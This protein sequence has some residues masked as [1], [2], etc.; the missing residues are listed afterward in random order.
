[1]TRRARVG[2]SPSL[3]PFLAVLVCTLG[4][5]ILLLALVAQNAT[6]S[7]K[8]QAEA[9]QA[10]E[11]LAADNA[12]PK[13]TREVV[14]RMIQ[15]GEFRVT[16]LVSFRDSQTADLEERRDK[17]THLEDHIR[18]IRDELTQLNREVELA[19]STSPLTKIEEN[20]VNELKAKL[21]SERKHVEELR[22]SAQSKKPRVVIVPHKG[23]NGTDRRPVYLECT[24]S[25]ITIWPESS[26]IEINELMAIESNSN[27]LDAALRTVRMY[28]MQN[29]GDT[30]PPYPLL[31]VR[32][33][34][35]ETYG[36]ARQ[37]MLDWDDQFGYELVPAD[38]DLAFAKPDSQ[39][40]QKVDIAIRDA[41]A[42]Q[43]RQ[44]SIAGLAIGR[45]GSA[46]GSGS[47]V[48]TLSAAELDRDG[49]SGGF[50]D[51]RDRSLP[52]G[53]YG[54]PTNY[55]SSGTSDNAAA[56]RLDEHLQNAAQE[57]AV[58]SPSNFDMPS[59]LSNQGA[60]GTNSGT[61]TGELNPLSQGMGEKS[62]GTPNSLT[63]NAL[64]TSSG[65]GTGL[66]MPGADSLAGS[67]SG[68]SAAGDKP[69]S[70]N[71]GDGASPSDGKSPNGTKSESTTSTGTTG[72]ASVAS[73]N[74]AS[75]D[76]KDQLGGEF[77]SGANQ[78]AGDGGTQMQ[79]GGSPTQQSSNAAGG[80]ASAR[81][82]SDESQSSPSVS[83][84]NATPPQSTR[85]SIQ[86]KG[87][88]WALPDNVAGLNGTA[89]VR[90]IRV[91][92]YNDRLV[93]LPPASGGATEMFGFS[94]GQID[95]ATLELASAVRDRIEMW[96][97]SLPG[98]RWQPRLDVEVTRD[99]TARFE[100]LRSLMNGSGVEV[101][102]RPSP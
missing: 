13:P 95:R 16:Q 34:G 12:E 76:S 70:S 66:Q 56:R 54:S 72:S 42:K 102:G 91:V 33:D 97:P 51:V 27:P 24:A 96:G 79:G 2:L 68:A 90:T 8:Q 14:D 61:G 1:M 41:V 31:V 7:A 69:Q 28:V 73:N 57:M 59:L 60:G 5:L 35:I 89:V 62:L 77:A 93:L 83:A 9:K 49:R 19:T 15:E 50:S 6:T 87:K 40:K 43:T 45:G 100:Q 22:E 81:G 39:L 92:C 82:S 63:E 17:I 86:R 10:A 25:G 18:R 36:A 38:V 101:I 98:G 4:T 99:G 44:S 88:D 74:A 85:K 84:S 46:G 65:S 29:Y 67:S 75:A 37:A 94:D 78:G 20:K 21:E 3:F 30:I 52:R 71:P 32:P 47:R 58:G 26:R 55:G 80:Q 11:K 53:S 64:S 23:P 48:R